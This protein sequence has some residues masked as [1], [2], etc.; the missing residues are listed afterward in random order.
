MN[1]AMVFA[2]T[3]AATKAKGEAMDLLSPFRE[4]RTYGHAVMAVE[5]VFAKEGAEAGL[6]KAKD[7]AE[8]YE[9][10]FLRDVIDASTRML[11]PGE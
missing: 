9:E 8:K 7:I 3:D 4:H 1:D 11:Q 6:A 10:I 2:A 5:R